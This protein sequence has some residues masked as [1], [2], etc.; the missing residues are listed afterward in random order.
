[1]QKPTPPNESVLKSPQDAALRQEEFGD[2]SQAADQFDAA[3]EYYAVALAQ[4]RPDDRA[5]RARLLIKLAECDHRQGRYDHALAQ[6]SG[7]RM[8]ARPLRDSTL[9]GLLASRIA[10]SHVAAGSYRPGTRYAR[11]AFRILRT[12]NEH[13][14]L[15]LIEQTQGIAALRTGDYPAALDAFT[16]SLASFRRVED[17]GHMAG[18]H[19]NL[20]LVYKNTGQWRE[21]TRSFEQALRLAEKVGDY[22]YVAYYAQNLGVMR[23]RLGELDLASECFRRALQIEIEISDHLAEIRTRLALGRL[24]VRRRQ[25]DQAADEFARAG[26]LL[27]ERNYPR[28][29]VLWREF[30]GE[31]ALD[32]GAL[33]EARTALEEALVGAERLAPDGDVTYEVTARLALAYLESGDLPRAQASAARAEHL[34]GAAGDVAELAIARR[35]SGLVSL[36]KGDDDAALADLR[37]AQ[38][39]FEELGDR[40]ELARTF[41]LGA[42]HALKSGATQGRVAD[43]A[44]DNLK[45]AE[46]LFR[47]LGVPA[48]AAEAAMLLARILAGRGNLDQA[49]GEIE[50]ALVWLRESGE[51]AG[52]T[53]VAQL[54]A[55]LEALSAAS[56]VSA[57]NEFHVLQ[58]AN[59]IFKSADDMHD[60]LSRTVRLA[61]ER[62]G[63]DRGFVAFA[64]GGGRLE[65]VAHHSLGAER[66]K[67]ALA[68]LERVMG[69][70]L[71]Q[72]A[73]VFKSRIAADPRFAGELSGPLSGVFSLVVVPLNFPSQA[74]GLVYVDRLSDNL[75]GAFKQREINLLAV[76]ANSAAVAMV[77]AQRSVL[78][79]ENQSLKQQLSPKPGLERIITQS[80]EMQEILALLEKVGDSTAS[81]LLMGETGTGK[82]LI[83]QAIHEMS[84]RRDK[85]FVAVNCAALPDNLLESELFGYVAGAFTG[86]TRDKDGLFKEADGGTIFLDE[87]EKISEP[88]QAKLLHVLD[89]GEIRPV[90]ATKSFQVNARVVA[91]TNAELRERIKAGRFL[92]DLYYRMN[93]IAIT[94]PPLRDRREDIPALTAHFLAFYARQMDK[95]VPQLA[96]AVQRALLNHEW[97]G[98]VRELEKT[99]KRLVVLA[100]PDVTVGTDLLPEDMR[101]PMETLLVGT[102]GS[103]NVREHVE[104]LERRLIREALESH[105]W[106]KTQ[107]AKSLGLSYPTL[108]SK[109]RLLALDRRRLRI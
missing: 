89:K 24:H 86:A 94:V 81:I 48:Q 78:L 79:Q 2:L 13:V 42:A 65:V 17:I 46:A 109:I 76:L 22:F 85:R 100:E 63:G 83:A 96:P 98:N 107:A 92:E 104:R 68:A 56:S 34:A 77:E 54:R 55:E 58:E 52:E 66:A 60:V 19:S 26:T 64:A 49:L 11:A 103:F 37:A 20:G 32:R 73:P 71:V 88:L 43:W 28:E 3:R 35:A 97:R 9:N 50:H 18:A 47:D 25:F 30:E 106:N 70:E 91:A 40:F 44:A 14:E 10:R 84:T 105:H 67:K 4:V 90:G 27:E 51:S 1:V 29:R 53:H 15:G 33:A 21:A 102:N 59:D 74:V 41:Q 87:I 101:A 61:V 31:A 80:R 23:F 75:R 69:R 93:D 108:L 62:S 45:R 38:A 16:G 7:A 8:A 36:V 82:G 99:V 57:S 39:S 12:T 95:P 5:T 72:G 6:L